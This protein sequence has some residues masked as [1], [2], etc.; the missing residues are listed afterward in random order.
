LASYRAYYTRWS[1]PWEEQALLRAR[2]VAGDQDLGRRFI[3]MIDPLRYPDA[4]IGPDDLVEVRRIKARVDAERLPR[5][6]DPATHLKLGRGGLS[7][8]EWTVQLMQLRHAAE[9]PSLRDTRT[10][11]TLDVLAQLGL[12]SET[13]VTTLREAWLL[14][15][16]IRNATM[17]ARGRQTDV[18]PAPPQERAA[19]AYICGYPVGHSER[20]L[21][22]YLRK[23]RRASRVVQDVFWS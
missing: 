5:G 21:D 8:V 1:R 16:R 6:A 9:Y 7:D 13:E 4:G 23:S 15:S 18:L 17:L 20:L 14:A 22:E 3:E 19:V 10:I 11:A 12:L 2:P